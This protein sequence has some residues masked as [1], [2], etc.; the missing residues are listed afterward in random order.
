MVSDAIL[1]GSK[2][3]VKMYVNVLEKQGLKLRPAGCQCKLKL[4]VGDKNFEVSCN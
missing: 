2:D 3:R 1:L 4:S